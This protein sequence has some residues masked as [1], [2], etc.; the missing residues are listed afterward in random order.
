MIVQLLIWI[1]L[2]CMVGAFGG[3]LLCQFAL[4]A[5]VRRQDAVARGASRVLNLLIGVGLLAGAAIYGLKKGQLMGPHYNAVIGV[6]FGLLLAVGALVGMSKKPERGDVMRNLACVLL[7]LA[8][9]LGST[10]V[11]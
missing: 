2:I 3:L 7:A 5:D 1:H 9:L 4:P 11:P 10:L 8:A 6:K